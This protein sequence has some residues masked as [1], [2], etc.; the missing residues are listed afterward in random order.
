MLGRRLQHGSDLSTEAVEVVVTIERLPNVLQCFGFVAPAER[1][2]LNLDGLAVVA[3]LF[4][5]GVFLGTI[6]RC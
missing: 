6:G 3:V 4:E 5:N 2:R 1:D